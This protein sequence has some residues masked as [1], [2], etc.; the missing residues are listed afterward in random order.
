MIVE[1]IYDAIQKE[2]KKLPK[3]AKVNMFENC[4]GGV[5]GG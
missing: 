2:G 5:V 4:E 3:Q 1:T